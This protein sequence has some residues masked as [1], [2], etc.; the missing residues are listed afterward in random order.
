MQKSRIVQAIQSR[1]E[2]VAMTGDG[3]NDAPALARADVGVAMGH[4][5]TEVAK[6]AAKLVITDDNF[7]TI[8][9]AIEQGRVVYHNIKKVIYY[10]LA[11]SLSVVILLFFAIIFGYPLPLTA[12][13]ILWLNVVTEGSVTI[14]LIIDPPEGDEMKHPPVKLT[15]PLLT[16]FIIRKIAVTAPL[17]GSLLLGYFIFNWRPGTNLCELQTEVFTLFAFSAW[18]KLFSARSEVK[19]IFHLNPFRNPY[20][21]LGLT[22]GVAL[23]ACILYIPML[24][25]LFGTYPIGFITLLHLFELASLVLIAEEIPPPAPPWDRARPAIHRASK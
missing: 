18:F 22:V 1:G 25:E 8:L 20:L 10:L 19:S 24:N 17:L 5:W 15:D 9:K 11:T 13:Q 7:A 21:M 16:R 12:V 23:H 2:V 6:Q 14:N 4:R 3:V